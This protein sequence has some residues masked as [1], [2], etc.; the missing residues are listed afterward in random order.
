MDNA[1][2]ERILFLI[3]IVLSVLLGVSI[4]LHYNKNPSINQNQNIN[5][6][7]DSKENNKINLN[8]AS[9]KVLASL[10]LIGEKKAKNIIEYRNKNGNFN[11]INDLLNV[12]EIGQNTLNAIKDKAVV[13]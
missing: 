7:F 1:K 11:N 8:T 5:L 2:K 6:N 4:G 3:I 10:P 9:E 13:K 12:K